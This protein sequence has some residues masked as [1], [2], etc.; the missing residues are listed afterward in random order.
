MESQ[1]LAVCALAIVLSLL[2]CSLAVGS[3]VVSF[4][5]HRTLRQ[6]SRSEVLLTLRGGS[7]A[8][9]TQTSFDAESLLRRY[10]EEESKK[11]GK[12]FIQGWRWHTMSVM[13]EAERLQ[14]LALRIAGN[15]T[16]AGPAELHKAAD[17]VVDFNLQALHRVERMFFPFVRKGIADSNDLANPQIN[18]AV[19]SVLKGLEEDQKKLSE[20]GKSIVSTKLNSS[21]AS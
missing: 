12:F 10:F 15:E 19:E 8:S 7:T 3:Q 16:M 6:L 20:L 17:Y 1:R 9:T 5:R 11:E 14:K 2:C 18:I 13:R 4:P 21:F